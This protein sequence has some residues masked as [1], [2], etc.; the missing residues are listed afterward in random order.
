MLKLLAGRAHRV[1]GVD[2]DAGARQMARAELMLAGLPNCTLRQGDMYQLPFN[3]AEFDTI[4]LDDVLGTAIRPVAVLTEAARL[5]R[6]NGRLFILMALPHA[7]GQELPR[8]VADW[9]STAG[10]R[11]APVRLV[12]KK[13]PCWLVSVA[14]VPQSQGVAA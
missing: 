4:I 12:P 9:S 10:L 3:D 13:N 1:V 8:A 6:K 11:L 5:L 7:P 14:T 2:I